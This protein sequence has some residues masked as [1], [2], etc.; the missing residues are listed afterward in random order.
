M[1]IVIELRIFVDKK[2]SFFTHND[3]KKKNF[4]IFSIK[5]ENGIYSIYF[6][7]TTMKNFLQL[8][9]ELAKST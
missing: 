3:I 6:P 9:F 5:F 7:H 8:F 1:T 2:I 4:Q